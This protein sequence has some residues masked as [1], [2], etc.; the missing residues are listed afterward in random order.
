M[1]TRRHRPVESLFR[2]AT[3][4]ALTGTLA[5]VG[6]GHPG[7]GTIKVS[8]EARARLTPH[9]PVMTKGPKARIVGQRPIGIKDRGVRTSTP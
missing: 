4:L 7:E 2:S 9:V 8:S 6:C 3:C 5:V 1:I